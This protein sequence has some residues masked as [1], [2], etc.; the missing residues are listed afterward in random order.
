[1]HASR[2]HVTRTVFALALC[3]ATTQPQ[4]ADVP[5]I[6][7]WASVYAMPSRELTVRSVGH[8]R[9]IYGW[10]CVRTLGVHQIHDFAASGSRPGAVTATGSPTRL[11]TRFDDWELTATVNRDGDTAEIAGQRL[12]TKLDLT[13]TRTGPENAPC[14]PRILPLRAPGVPDDDRPA[15][16]TFAEAI[17]AARAGETHPLV[18]TWSGRRR[19]FAI[20]LSI[21]SVDDGTVSGLYCVTWASGWRALDIDPEI[22]GAIAESATKN[23]LTFT[24]KKRHFSFRL[25]GPNTMTRHLSRPGKTMRTLQM[26]RTQ[27]PVCAPRVIM[28]T[29]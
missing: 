22:P 10:Y 12:L 26:V 21:A 27:A 24:Y 13:F 4:A 5:L 23:E 19:G 7:T 15:G 6:G 11:H 2:L 14:R 25:D 20:E 3:L 29:T 8:G 28:P 17:A 1:M 18:G 16:Q 9:L